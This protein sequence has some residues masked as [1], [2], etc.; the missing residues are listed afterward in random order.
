MN[1]L[2]LSLFTVSDS[3][4]NR[5]KRGTVSKS[6]TSV[7]MSVV[8]VIWA[9]RSQKRALRSKKIEKNHI[10]RRFWQFFT[11]F[12]LFMPKSKSLMLLF[13]KEQREHFAHSSLYKRA[14]VSD[15]LRSLMTKER[16]WAFHSFR[17]R[18]T[19]SLSTEYQIFCDCSERNMSTTL[20]MMLHTSEMLQVVYKNIFVVHLG[21]S[22]GV[23][24]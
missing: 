11:A 7:K 24:Q 15:S 5:D 13:F 16:L 1:K 21:S 10:F 23:V 2:L 12:P 17:K 3:Q 4:V 8:L 9:N 6:L 14:T 20:K 19:L 18:L 22:S